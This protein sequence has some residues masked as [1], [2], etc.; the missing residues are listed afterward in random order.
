MANV[1]D[2]NMIIRSSQRNRRFSIKDD[3]LR[4]PLG[5]Q[6]TSLLWTDFLGN[7]TKPLYT[8]YHYVKMPMGFEQ[9]GWT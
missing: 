3:R 1:N 9:L 4:H 5:G 8:S 7:L 6:A 2:A